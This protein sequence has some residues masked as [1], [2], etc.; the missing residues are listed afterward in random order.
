MRL[1]QS[2]GERGMADEGVAEVGRLKLPI[3]VVVTAML[4]AAVMEDGVGIGIAVAVGIA[5]IDIGVAS[6]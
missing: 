4:A 5:V 6:A 2:L 3:T 1:A